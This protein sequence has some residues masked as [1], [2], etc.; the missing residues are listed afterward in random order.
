M[1]WLIAGLVLAAVALFLRRLLH[2]GTHTKKP[3]NLQASIPDD[4]HPLYH[5]VAQEIETQAAI[6]GITLND[7]FGER[8]AGRHEMSWHV[9]HLARGEWERLTNLV[10][11]LQ[12]VLARFLPAAEGVVIQRRV[13][14][15]HF[16]SRSVI[17]HV[18]LHEFLDQILFSSKRRFAL[19]LRFLSRTAALVSKEFHH[20]CGEGERTLDSSSELWTRLD[21]LFHDFDLIGKETLLAFRTLLASQTPARA[22]ALA[23]E[24]NELLGRTTRVSVTV[25]NPSTS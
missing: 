13:A 25:S 16:K 7:A 23:S 10:L 11:G 2:I 21:H 18:A 6:L 17:E 22:Q 19:Q 9:V 20:A 12:I 15:G 24:L 8:E 14:V 3:A 4:L 1:R 5:P